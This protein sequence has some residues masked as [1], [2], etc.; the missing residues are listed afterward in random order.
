VW[1]A[2]RPLQALHEKRKPAQTSTPHGRCMN[3]YMA[4]KQ[5]LLSKYRRK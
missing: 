5:L 4:K 1:S 2:R 3:N